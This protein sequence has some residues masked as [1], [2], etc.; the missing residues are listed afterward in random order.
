MWRREG[1]NDEE[2]RR[3]VLMYGT[4]KSERCL[5]YLRLRNPVFIMNGALTDE[6][7][8]YSLQITSPAVVI[9]SR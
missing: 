3:R 8:G 5:W 4:R 6:H 2:N 9:G 1:I 7:P